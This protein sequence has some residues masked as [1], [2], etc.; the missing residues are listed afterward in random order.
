MF[1]LCVCVYIPMQI[2]TTQIIPVFL[3]S[4]TGNLG[5]YCVCCALR[6]CFVMQQNVVF[7]KTINWSLVIAVLKSKF[8]LKKFLVCWFVFLPLISCIDLSQLSIVWRTNKK[9]HLKKERN[10][11][12]ACKPTIKFCGYK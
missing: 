4:W 9:E 11:M 8:F 12:A 2:N 5:I 6:C 7:N 1:C 10:K 3:Q